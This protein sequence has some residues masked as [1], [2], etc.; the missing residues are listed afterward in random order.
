MKPF[1]MSRAMYTGTVMLRFM[2]NI[3][4]PMGS[5]QLLTHRGRKSGKL[6]TTPVALVQK[7]GKR[8]LVAAF[9][10]VNWVKNIRTAGSAQLGSGKH[11]ETV[12]FVELNASEAAPVLQQF[13]K[14]YRFVP[15]IPP[16]FEVTPE[17]S[18]AEFEHEA[19]HHPV[20][21]VVEQKGR[22]V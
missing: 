7:D 1:K 11:A 19:I 20:F 21:R 22:I 9:G 3:G 6:Y 13:L 5:L 4:L 16:Y 17:S 14:S 8:W 15:F 18:L 12:Q 2:L 10:E